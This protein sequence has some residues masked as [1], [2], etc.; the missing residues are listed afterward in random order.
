M[1]ITSKQV[2]IPFVAAAAILV[3]AVTMGGLAYANGPGGDSTTLLTKVA[4][5]LSISVD[6]LTQAF[7][8]ARVELIHTYLKVFRQPHLN[9]VIEGQGEKRLRGPRGRH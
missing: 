8:D 7:K 1:K 9:A 3:G 2:L 6:T 5:K 4:S